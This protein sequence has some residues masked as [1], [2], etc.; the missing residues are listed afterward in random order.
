MLDMFRMLIHPSSGAC[1]LFV[2]LLHGL[3]WSGSM[4]VGVTLWFGCGGVVSV[5]RRREIGIFI[6][7]FFSVCRSRPKRRMW[8]CSYVI[9]KGQNFI[10]PCMALST[11]KTTK[12]AQMFCVVSSRC[13]YSSCHLQSKNWRCIFFQNV[14]TYLNNACRY[15]SNYRQERKSHVT[16][17]TVHTTYTAALKTTT[18]PKTR[19]RKPYAATQ[20]LMLLMMGVCT[21]NM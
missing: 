18:H 1:D 5:C 8:T 3:Y 4:C 13:I 9:P 6:E 7:V 19:C 21:R 2:E 14:R 20:H 10:E 11:A 16:I 15:S 12:N 17:R